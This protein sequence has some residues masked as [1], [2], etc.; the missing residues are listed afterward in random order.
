[1][2]QTFTIDPTHSRVSFTFDHLGFS[3]PLVQLEQ[4]KG[5]LVVD[6]SDWTKSSVSVTMPL[7]GLHTGT[8]KLDEHLRSADFF[9]VGKFPN[10]TFKSAK[11]TKTGTDTLDITG[12]LSAHGITRPVTLHTRV[13][14]IGENKLTSSQTAGFEADAVLKRSEFGMDEFVPA[15]LDEV[16]VH[17][18]LS[19]DLAK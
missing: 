3:H 12:D 17:I 11:V 2:Q 9:D 4:I 7:A 15:I 19:A 6:Q 13:N 5:T 16:P 18:T 1:M 10:V 8:D 14:R